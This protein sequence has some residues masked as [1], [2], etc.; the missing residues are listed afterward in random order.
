MNGSMDSFNVRVSFTS[1][2]FAARLAFAAAIPS[3]LISSG[4]NFSA[5][6]FTSG[7]RM[8]IPIRSHSPTKMLIFS[9]FDTSLL[10]TAAMN[11]T[12]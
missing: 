1:I 10:M 11:S 8:R 2:S 6:L 12:G 3:S 9:V 5:D 4:V 7:G